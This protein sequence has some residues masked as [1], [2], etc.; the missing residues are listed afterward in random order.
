MHTSHVLGR[1]QAPVAV[2][3][4]PDPTFTERRDMH[5]RL[6]LSVEMLVAGASLLVAASF[7]TT[8]TTSNALKQGRVWK[9]GTT[10]V[11]V[12]NDPQISDITNTWRSQNATTTKLNN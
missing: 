2:R 3:G 10:G 12:Q 6:W 5:R 9:Y 7:A 8:G 11:S 4:C 1:G